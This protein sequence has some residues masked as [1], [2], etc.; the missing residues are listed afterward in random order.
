MKRFVR[1]FVLVCWGYLSAGA[2]PP[3][4]VYFAEAHRTAWQQLQDYTPLARH[5]LGDTSVAEA[6]AVVYPE[7]LRY[8][9][10]RDEVEMYVLRQLYVRYGAGYANFSV[11]LF[12][13]KPS[14]AETVEQLA[15]RYGCDCPLAFTETTP[16]QQRRQRLQCL[17]QIEGQLL[18]LKA[19]LCVAYAR[20][21]ALSQMPPEKRIPFLA[22]L[23]NY[24][25]EASEEE[26][27]SW[28][29]VKAFPY[30]RYHTIRYAYAALAWRFYE[31]W[32]LQKP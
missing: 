7:L 2:Q 27:R 3:V 25:I 8:S 28:M 31:Q 26:I 30:G 18:Y 20:F 32:T 16:E 10:L 24:G 5:L 14:F 15:R 29:K 1:L 17:T 19:F 13:M 12:Q 21:P 4:E 6:W 23:Y 9:L 11:G 22:A